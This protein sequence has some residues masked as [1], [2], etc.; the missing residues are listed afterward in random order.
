MEGALPDP[1][2]EPHSGFNN[3]HSVPTERDSHSVSKHSVGM[4]ISLLTNRQGRASSDRMSYSRKSGG[5]DWP[6]AKSALFLCSRLA[7]CKH[8][9]RLLPPYRLCPSRHDTSDHVTD[10]QARCSSITPLSRTG[11]YTQVRCQ[12]LERA[13]GMIRSRS[14]RVD[15]RDLPLRFALL[16]QACSGSN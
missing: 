3:N 7:A 5:Q 11:A 4:I 16:R 14:A 12:A 15:I 6:S 8:D 2:I 10:S 1:P 9:N 13:R